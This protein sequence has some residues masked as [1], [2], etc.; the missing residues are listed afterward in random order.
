MLVSII[1]LAFATA[2]AS[3]AQ[4]GGRKLSADVPFDF[5]VGDKTLAAGQYSVRQIST[6]SDSVL[7]IRSRDGNHKAARLTNAV[8]SGAPSK[9][10][11]L[12]FRRYGNTYYLAQVWVPGS[13]EGRE[14]LKS[15]AER[16]MERELA[17]S[18]PTDN[19]AREAKAE[20]VTIAAEVE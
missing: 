3:N 13:T 4:S 6:N 10:A 7:A 19:P 2:V 11:S 12:T 5:V 16:S 17:K 18:S 9:R 20:I 14:M 15:K 8:S 1:V